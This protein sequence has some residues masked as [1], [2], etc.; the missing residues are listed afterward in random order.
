MGW[1]ECK[2]RLTWRRSTISR[3]LLYAETALYYICI[4]IHMHTFNIKVEEGI[5]EEA[6]ESMR[7][8]EDGW[9]KSVRVVNMNKT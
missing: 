4:L 5:W 7:E 9:E 1:A 3:V 6:K 2:S 8:Q